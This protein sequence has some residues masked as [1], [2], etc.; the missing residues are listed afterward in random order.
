MPQDAI[1]LALL[2]FNVGVEMGQLLFVA[3]VLVPLVLCARLSLPRW[4]R[5]AEATAL[6]IGTVASYWTFERIAG[7]FCAKRRANVVSG[8]DVV[9]T[10]GAFKLFLYPQEGLEFAGFEFVDGVAHCY[11]G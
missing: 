2:F 1:P 6:G 11:A 5:L 4:P 3:A 8:K 9:H 10:G 7:L